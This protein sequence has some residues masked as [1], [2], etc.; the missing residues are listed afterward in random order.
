L[1]GDAIL[2]ALIA[3]PAVKSVRGDRRPPP[4]GAILI[5]VH[6]EGI[7]QIG[8]IVQ[9][10]GRMGLCRGYRFNRSIEMDR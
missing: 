10:L 6:G 5:V 4:A 1:A 3:E 8:A 7:V 9:M 2:A